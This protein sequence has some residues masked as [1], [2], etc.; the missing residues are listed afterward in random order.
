MPDPHFSS[1]ISGVT[2]RVKIF[3]DLKILVFN[4]TRFNFNFNLKYRISAKFNA[5]ISLTYAFFHAADVKGSN[6]DR[7][8]E[9][10][11][12]GFEPALLGEYYFIKNK[13]ERSYLF[14]KGRGTGF[15]SILRS[16]DFYVFTGVGGLSYTDKR[17]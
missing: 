6:E 3:S 14:S 1:V 5:R 4:Q 7:D 16:L 10:S 12:T 15:G 9:A 17:K 2:P 13:A 8:F 11:M